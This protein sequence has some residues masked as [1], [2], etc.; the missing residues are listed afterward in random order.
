MS[1]DSET[2]ENTKKGSLAEVTDDSCTVKFLDTSS[3]GK[4]EDLQEMKE[5]PADESDNEDVNYSL[6]QES[7]DEYQTE[8][9]SFT[10]P[11]QV[12]TTVHIQLIL[13]VV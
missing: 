7:T 13:T 3:G 10:V 9:S 11:V 12:R 4:P 6:K 5:E 2:V 8:F 1:D